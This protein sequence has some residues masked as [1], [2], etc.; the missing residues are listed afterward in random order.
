MGFKK[1]VLSPVGA[2]NVISYKRHEEEREMA[3]A[4]V[5]TGLLTENTV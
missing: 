4:I 2:N 5:R 1:T 3:D